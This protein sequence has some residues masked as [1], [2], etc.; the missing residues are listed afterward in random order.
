[1]R[2]ILMCGLVCVL[3]F[4]RG[5]CDEIQTDLENDVFEDVFAAGEKLPEKRAL[6][7]RKAGPGNCGYGFWC[8]EK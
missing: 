3:M 1:M 7:K 4:A 6:P 8:V 2:F 5:Q